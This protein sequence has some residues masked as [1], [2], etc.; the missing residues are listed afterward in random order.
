GLLGAVQHHAVAAVEIQCVN[1]IVETGKQVLQALADTLLVEIEN[2]EA[3]AQIATAQLVIQQQAVAVERLDVAGEEIHPVRV[4][5]AQVAV[6]HFLRQAV[7]KAQL[8]VVSLQAVNDAARGSGVDFFRGQ[9][10]GGNG[11]G[12]RAD[13]EGAADLQQRGNQQGNNAE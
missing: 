2:I 8:P 4:Q 1:A 12:A 3:G 9:A 10:A 5:V 6:E 7:I 13:G 11:L